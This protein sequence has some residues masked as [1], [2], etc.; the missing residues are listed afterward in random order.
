LFLFSTLQEGEYMNDI[1]LDN[2]FDNDYLEEELPDSMFDVY[3]RRFSQDPLVFR[4][5]EVLEINGT[6]ASTFHLVNY[7]KNVIEMGPREVKEPWYDIEHDESCVDSTF[8]W[9][10]SYCEGSRKIFPDVP[11][12]APVISDRYCKPVRDYRLQRYF[13]NNG[14]SLVDPTYGELASLGD[15]VDLC[16][17]IQRVSKKCFSMMLRVRRNYFILIEIFHEIVRIIVS[18]YSLILIIL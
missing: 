14:F 18:D 10:K 5:K 12:S 9:Y 6:L 3:A 4:S 13:M 8:E 11:I 1:Y 15:V 16:L 2:F 17:I 7:D